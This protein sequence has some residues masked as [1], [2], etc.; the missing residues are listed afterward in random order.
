ME[1]NAGLK[2]ILPEME[3]NS[4]KNVSAIIKNS[5]FKSFPIW[6]TLQH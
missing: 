6:K 4:K 2:N 3:K 5:S 1:R